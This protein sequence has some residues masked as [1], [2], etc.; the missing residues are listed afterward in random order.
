MARPLRIDREDTFYHVLN[1][2]NERRAIFRDDGDR[3]GFLTR[4]GRCAE[5][6]GLEIYAYVLMGNHYHLLVRTRGAL[7]SGTISSRSRSVPSR[8]MR[9]AMTDCMCVSAP[10]AVPSATWITR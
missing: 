7:S 3:E 10:E 4:L 6:F 9:S 1:R 2:G 5:R 8:T